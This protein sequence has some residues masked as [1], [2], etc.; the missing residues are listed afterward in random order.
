METALRLQSF[1]RDEKGATAIEYALIAGIV[2]IVITSSV[3]GISQ[4][5]STIFTDVNDGLDTANQAN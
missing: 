3:L 4:S 2:S 1:I 5:L